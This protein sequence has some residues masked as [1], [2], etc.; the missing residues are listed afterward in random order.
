MVALKTISLRQVNPFEEKLFND[1]DINLQKHG[2]GSKLVT[3]GAI[4]LSS[5]VY[6]YSQLNVK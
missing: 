1:S 4:A 3:Y 2:A 6:Y 5:H